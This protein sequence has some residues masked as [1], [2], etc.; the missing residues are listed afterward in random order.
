MQKN[1]FFLFSFRRKC[2]EDI[3]EDRLLFSSVLHSNCLYWLY[4]KVL[5]ILKLHML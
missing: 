5:F 1:S 3:H 2:F 4:F